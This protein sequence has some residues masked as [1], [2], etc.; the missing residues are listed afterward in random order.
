MRGVAALVCVV[1]GA[2]DDGVVIEVRPAPGTKPGSVDIYLGLDPCLKNDDPNTPCDALQPP[3]AKQALRGDVFFRDANETFTVDADADGI[4]RLKL[5]SSEAGAQLPI[6]VAVDDAQSMAAIALDVDLDKTSR[7]VMELAPAKGSL[8]TGQPAGVYLQIWN[9]MKEPKTS[10]LGFELVS[11]DDN[12]TRN[13]DRYFVVPKE[14]PDCD[15]FDA[16]N[17]ECNPLAYQATSSPSIDKVSCVKAFAEPVSACRLGGPGCVDG[18]QGSTVCGPSEFCVPNTFCTTCSNRTTAADLR[19]CLASTIAATTGTP[20]IECGLPMQLSSDNTHL[21][22]CEGAA[23]FL[24]DATASVGTCLDGPA[25]IEKPGA[26]EPLAFVDQIELPGDQN[27]ATSIM[28]R[29]RRDSGCNYKMEWGGQAGLQAVLLE[30]AVARFATEQS[31]L[32]VPIHFTVVK[33]GCVAPFS[34]HL[35]GFTNRTDDLWRCAP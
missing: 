34:C 27:G 18:V 2:C 14:D 6:I 9:K 3:G 16:S 19:T 21:D 33:D 8:G 32:L 23:T 26:M 35:E 29:M 31:S 25:L 17:F 15:D 7:Y 12:N 1:L 30:P 28:F 24:Y 10:C 20:H 5:K 11:T 22:P 4:A 13:V